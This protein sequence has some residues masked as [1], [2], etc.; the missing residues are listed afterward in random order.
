MLERAFRNIYNHVRLVS[1]K[2]IDFAMTPAIG[3]KTFRMW[4]RTLWRP[5]LVMFYG[6]VLVMLIVLVNVLNSVWWR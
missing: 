2:N 3:D 6:I 1:V 5:V 4:F